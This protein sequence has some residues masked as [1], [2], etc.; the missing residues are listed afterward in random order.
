M[1]LPK[2]AAKILSGSV[3]N[4]VVMAGAGNVLVYL[5]LIDECDF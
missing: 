4:V 1:D 2:I 5:D 3:R